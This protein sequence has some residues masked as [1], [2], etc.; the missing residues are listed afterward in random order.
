MGGGFRDG[1]V[2]QSWHS[3]PVQVEKGTG[4]VIPI[5]SAICNLLKLRPKSA[6]FAA[7]VTGLSVCV[8][9]LVSPAGGVLHL[10][11]DD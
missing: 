4:H 7:Q 11:T 9:L 2:E 10:V 6:T 8:S 5:T 1:V 3:K